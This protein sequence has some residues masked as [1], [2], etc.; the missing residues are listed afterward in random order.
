[1]KNKQKSLKKQG[2]RTFVI[3][4]SIMLVF[5]LLVFGVYA[6]ITL[7]NEN[8]IQ[9]KQSNELFY[10]FQNEAD[11]CYNLNIVSNSVSYIIQS[12]SDNNTKIKF[13]EDLLTFKRNKKPTYESNNSLP[14][15]FV[16][17]TGTLRDNF[18]GII[19]YE[20]FRNS[21][22]DEDYQE[23][24]NY[25]HTAPDENNNYSRY[26]LSCTEC[27]Y[28]WK[29]TELQYPED[30]IYPTKLDVLKIED[31]IDWYTQA[32]R[33]KEYSLDTSYMELSETRTNKIGN[34]DM[35]VIAESFFDGIFYQCCITDE[36][37]D[38]TLDATSNGSISGIYDA[39]GFNYIYYNTFSEPYS[40]QI[41]EYSEELKK[42]LFCYYHKYNILNECEDKLITMFIYI[43]TSFMAMGVLIAFMSWHNL[44]KQMKLEEK[45]RELTNSMAHDLK[46]P[47]FV[48]G[49]YAENLIENVHTDKK[50]HYAQMIY[51]KTQEMNRLVHNML[52]LSKLESN[53]FIPHMEEF[54]LVK[55]T[56]DILVQFK[57]AKEFNISLEGNDKAIINA[58]KDLIKRAISN[59]VQNAEKYSEDGKAVITISTNEFAI[60]NTCTKIKSN[61]IKK[62]W[63]PYYMGNNSARNNGSGLGLS[64]VKNIMQAHKFDFSARLENKEII[65]YFKFAISYTSHI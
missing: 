14:F 50:D 39:G 42:D 2:I 49:G 52:D 59:L 13:Y 47:L 63:E 9:Q 60:S 57:T 61:E 25:I 3:T 19:E 31:G 35:N 58:D 36:E 21:I 18:T 51:D 22:S 11:K 12:H 56:K 32:E 46:T 4:I 5:G 40:V 62:L 64:I 28:G 55:T 26:V 24:Y 33:I 38:K 1:M 41:T 29:N 30:I 45:R 43:L 65:F 6:Y 23:I 16:N 8:E 20:S 10:E 17:E 27:I 7:K 54:D 37:I 48:I 15:T 34:T 44:K 53:S